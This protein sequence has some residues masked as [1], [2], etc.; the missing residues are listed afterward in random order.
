MMKVDWAFEY[1][2]LLVT[3]I[4]SYALAYRDNYNCVLFFLLVAIVSTIML[5]VRISTLDKQVKAQ[6]RL[7]ASYGVKESQKSDKETSPDTRK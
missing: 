5:G 3:I 4:G 1:L 2:W 6:S 7:L